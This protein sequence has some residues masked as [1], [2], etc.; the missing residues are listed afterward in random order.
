MDHQRIFFSTYMALL[1]GASLSLL[2]D[3]LIRRDTGATTL[4]NFLDP[5]I[6]W[7]TILSSSIYYIG[8]PHI[9]WWSGKDEFRNTLVKWKMRGAVV[10]GVAVLFPVLTQCLTDILLLL[11]GEKVEYIFERLMYTPPIGLIL[12]AMCE[13]SG[14]NRSIRI[15][16]VNHED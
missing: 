8:S 3:M 11:Q 9:Q 13:M 6:H 14:V 4:V 1:Y 2:T 10:F 7:S 15:A 5:R 16:Y 12:T